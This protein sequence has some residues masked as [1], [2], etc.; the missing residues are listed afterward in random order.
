M[1]CAQGAKEAGRWAAVPPYRGQPRYG[2]RQCP[3]AS[4][5]PGPLAPSS[6]L[7]SGTHTPR[8]SRLH[9]TYPVYL[10]RSCTR[11][12]PI[13][14]PCV[15]PA[16]PAPYLIASPPGLQPRIAPCLR[17]GLPVRLLAPLITASG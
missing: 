9:R 16:R 17:V 15:S 7:S 10:V 11:I 4:K 8:G 13:Q 6:P 3:A 2:L 12:P 14:A 1:V 5:V